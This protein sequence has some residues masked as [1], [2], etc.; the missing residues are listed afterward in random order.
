M[1][2]FFSLPIFLFATNAFVHALKFANTVKAEIVLLHTFDAPSYDSSFFLLIIPFY[3]TQ[4][5][6]SKFEQFKDEVPKL[7]PLQKS[8]ICSTLHYAD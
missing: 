2:K 1:K 4:V 3:T 8:S 5:E 6:L 7:Q